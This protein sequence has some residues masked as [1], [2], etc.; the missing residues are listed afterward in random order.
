MQS[1]TSTFIENLD[2]VN[3]PKEHKQYASLAK[4]RMDGLSLYVINSGK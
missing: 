2:E 4:S 3:I 1:E